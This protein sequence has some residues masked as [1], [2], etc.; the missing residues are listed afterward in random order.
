MANTYVFDIETDNLLDDVTKIHCLSY[1]HVDKFEPVTL[2]TTE[3]I[4]NFLSQEKLTLI[5]HNICMYDVRVF[6]KL[7]GFDTSIIYKLVD[8]LGISWYLNSSKDKSFKH[9]LGAYGERLGVSKPKVE[10]WLEQ[11]IEV[12]IDRC[13]ED[14][15]INLLLWKQQQAELMELYER[16]SKEV[17]RIIDYIS[18]KLDCLVEQSEN[19]VPLDIDLMCSE[20]GRLDKLVVEKR[21]PLKDAMPKMPIKTT[22]NR[23]KVMHKADGSLSVAGTNWIDICSLYQLDFQSETIEYITGYDEP[24]PDSPIQVKDWLDS[25]GWKPAFFKFQRD[26]KTNAIKQIPQ[27][28]SEHDSTDICDSVKELIDIEPAIEYLASYSTIKHRLAVL[29]GFIR[30][31][32]DDF[33]LEGAA[34]GFT[35]TFRLKHKTIVNL[36][37]PSA[38]YAE[39]IRACLIAGEGKYMVGSDLS[40]I[41]DSLKQLYI[42]DLDPDYVNEMRTDGFDPHIAIAI[43]AKLMTKEEEVLYKRI[44]KT[45]DKST[46]SK[47]DITEFKRLK[48]V[49][50]VSKQVNFSAQYSVGVKTLARNMKTTEKEA[51][52]I[53]DAYWEKNK[54]VKVFTASLEVKTINGQM[55]LKQPISKFW[56]TLRYDKDKLSTGVQGSAVYIFDMWLKGIRERGVK[57]FMQI[58]DE[59]MTILDSDFDKDKI[60]QIA[61]DSIKDINDMLNS[62]VKMGCSLD[63]G[64]NYCEVH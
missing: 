9:G 60:K 37:K 39:N 44:D 30:D 59:F 6:K 25:L 62:P 27:I 17:V 12:Y 4:V 5:G 1:T 50:H 11:P 56:Y 23:P 55:W 31:M 24:N 14:I 18:F 49:R 35:N 42:Y 22:R 41:E 45:E 26:K 8:T 21:I 15:K 2:T 7:L 20:I 38:P 32:D 19:R 3:E 43:Q 34:A 28:K 29:K 46:V 36:P 58:H 63:M 40:S 47:E 33:K 51:K 64:L 61:N 16:D 13:T 54:A 10:D 48:E 53:L 57:V 52:K